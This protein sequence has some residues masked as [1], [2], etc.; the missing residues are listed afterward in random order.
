MALFYQV[1]SVETIFEQEKQWLIGKGSAL[2]N[3]N[4]GGRTRSILHATAQIMH[5]TQFDFLQ[6][7]RKAIPTSVYNGFEFTRL[8]GNKATGSLQFG[9]NTPATVQITLPVGTSMV[10]NGITYETIEESTIEIGNTLTP[11]IS[12]RATVE[13]T[14]ANIAINAINTQLG[15]GTFA[16]QPE[17]I[18]FA[19]NSAPFGGG[20]FEESDEARLKRFRLYI[21]GLART[22]PTGIEAGSLTVPGVLSATVVSGY[23]SPGFVTVF[24]DDGTGVLAPDVK[25]ELERI[26]NGDPA[27]SFNVPGYRAAGIQILVEPPVVKAIDVTFEIRVLNSAQS[28]D[29]ELEEIALNAALGYV[30]TLTLGF[31]FIQSEMVC[32]VKLAHPDI[33]DVIISIPTSNVAVNPNQVVRSGTA[34]APVDGKF[35]TVTSQR[36]GP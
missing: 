31:D 15:Q 14:D 7:I 30:N 12:S 18:D 10:L 34:S 19:T 22:T 13:G 21:N 20:T 36:V 17:G 24:A 2:T 16:N 8:P 4:D 23:P 33:Y 11:G 28:V 27:D 26:L 32:S 6:G 35:I 9:R 25:T 29:S 3:F 1:K 5:E